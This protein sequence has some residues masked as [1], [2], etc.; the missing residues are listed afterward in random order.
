M[1]TN[2]KATEQLLAQ[3]MQSAYG[4]ANT[5]SSKSPFDEA[6]SFMQPNK[7]N[8]FDIFTYNPSTISSVLADRSQTKMKDQARSMVPDSGSF[9]KTIMDRDLYSG[10]EDKYVNAMSGIANKYLSEYSKNPYYAF[11]KEGKTL[12]TKMQQLAT[13]PSITHYEDVKTQT[14]KVKKVAEEKDI[15][16]NPIVNNGRVK[17]IRNGEFRYV[18]PSNV[19]KED[20]LVTV[21][22]NYSMIESGQSD[23]ALEVNMSSYEDVWDKITESMEGIGTTTVT[24]L[25]G[26]SKVDSKSQSEQKQFRKEWLAS[27]GLSQADYDTLTSEYIKR[28]GTPPTDAHLNGWIFGNLEKYMNSGEDQTVVNASG[29]V[30]NADGT[31][32][33]IADGSNLTANKNYFQEA[34]VGGLSAKAVISNS[35]TAEGVAKNNAISEETLK[36][37]PPALKKLLNKTQIDI[38]KPITN[39]I[40]GLSYSGQRYVDP[41]GEAKPI[42]NN[43]VPLDIN[44]LI[45]IIK[46]SNSQI[47]TP[48]G[49]DVPLSTTIPDVTRNSFLVIEKGQSVLYVPVLMSSNEWN[50]REPDVVEDSEFVG[51]EDEMGVY[52]NNL[53]GDNVELN[54]DNE[55][56]KQYLNVMQ[57]MEDVAWLKGGLRPNE[58]LYQG[59]VKISL[60]ENYE[61]ELAIFSKGNLYAPKAANATMGIQAGIENQSKSQIQ[62][63]YIE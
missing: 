8:E 5:P 9:I 17:V 53:G 32:S 30:T 60:A 45:N 44:P 36:T 38:V 6:L 59:M 12:A 46:D 27:Q 63:Q 50:S 52:M 49:E 47:T 35:T 4:P 22:E 15:W 7:A 58:E 39:N 1:A 43:Q 3:M 40:W 37:I 61:Q 16:G 13:D 54:D 21:G 20:R 57:H 42:S 2:N 62:T 28:N 31:I 48:D 41:E 24:T 34:F 25:F 55:L 33:S 11:T 26:K 19:K 18:K 51:I 23:E 56:S 14:E 29:A 10:T